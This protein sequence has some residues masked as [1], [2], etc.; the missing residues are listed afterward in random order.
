MEKRNQYLVPATAIHPGEFILDEIEVLGMS[1]AELARKMGVQPSLLNEV[2]KGRRGVTAIHALLLEKVLGIEAEFWMNLQ[3]RYELNKARISENVRRRESAI[4]RWNIVKDVL[5]VRYLRKQ[6]V[7]SGDPL[8]DVAA[9]DEVFGSADFNELRSRVSHLGSS[10]LKG[11]EKLSP[12]NVYTWMELVKHKALMT[13]VA[14]FDPDSWSNLDSELRNV[15]TRNRGVRLQCQI[16]L[17]RFGVKLIFQ[18]QPERAPID[19]FAFWSV[20]NPALALTMRHRSIDSFASSLYHALGHVFLH[21]AFNHQHEFLDL[22]RRGQLLNQCA[23]SESEASAF[24]SHFL[25]P[26]SLW[27]EFLAKGSYED[28]NIEAFACKIRMH[29]AVVLGRL[30]SKREI[31]GSF[32]QSKIE[33]SIG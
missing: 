1:Q 15:L 20:E 19:G 6:K 24:A 16:V 11:A 17:E 25:L 3:S 10:K 22:Y 4:E 30:R 32:S 26:E 8:E 23:K 7:L 12:V 28:E 13:G 29:P 9:L 2:I 14:T 5:P 33:R 18:E 31:K 21:L 27:V